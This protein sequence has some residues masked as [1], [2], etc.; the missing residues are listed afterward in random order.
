MISPAEKKNLTVF[1]E[2]PSK[3]LDA[4]LYSSI[5]SQKRK[6]R[7]MLKSYNSEQP[8]QFL[9]QLLIVPDH[10]LRNP[11]CTIYLVRGKI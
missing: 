6:S 10:R 4:K 9:E 8:G 3:N 11:D 2:K 5:K 7:V 1:I